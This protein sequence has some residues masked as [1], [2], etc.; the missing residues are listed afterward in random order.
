MIN[1]RKDVH[2]LA[3]ADWIESLSNEVIRDDD[4]GMREFTGHAERRDFAFDDVEQ[5]EFLR[6]CI[7]STIAKGGIPFELRFDGPRST[8]V[9]RHDLGSTPQEIE[10]AVIVWW[11]KDRSR[12]YDEDD[13]RFCTRDMIGSVF[14]HDTN[15]WE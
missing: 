12:S 2:G 14:N 1:K 11:S 5:E 15:S 10:D 8:Y 3:P 9:A 4:V 13:I 6:S 7:R